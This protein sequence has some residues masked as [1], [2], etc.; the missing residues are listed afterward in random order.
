M[1][2]LVKPFVNTMQNRPVEE[3]LHFHLELYRDIFELEFLGVILFNPFNKS[4]NIVIENN[5]V[6]YNQLYFQELAKYDYL[7]D[8][9]IKKM[10]PVMLNNYSIT[11]PDE[12][13]YYHESQKSR[14]FGDACYVPILYDN[15]FTGFFGLVKSHGSRD[16]T[17]KD[18]SILNRIS[19]YFNNSLKHTI[20]ENYRQSISH[21]TGNDIYLGH[22]FINTE[23][24]V[25]TG[26]TYEVFS[27]IRHFFP[28][29]TTTRESIQL[30]SITD[31][32]FYLFL[33]NSLPSFSFKNDCLDCT[34]YKDNFYTDNSQVVH[35]FIT[36]YSVYLTSLINRDSLLDIRVQDFL[37][38]DRE[39][40][41]VQ[42]ILSG[43]SNSDISVKLGISPETVKKHLYNVFQKAGVRSRTQLVFKVMGG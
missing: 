38:T 17:I 32:N 4:Q 24:E 10:N 34:I 7:A 1:K 41:I 29:N 33:K 3:T 16:F 22:L 2:P 18:F 9:M 14:P 19:K 40:A 25:I 21:N 31:R 15:T 26:M 5:P 43:F 36:G 27:L 42:C 30:E 12:K 28:Q 23:K 8:A 39:K 11:T 37:F 35:N 6:D 13:F 20:T